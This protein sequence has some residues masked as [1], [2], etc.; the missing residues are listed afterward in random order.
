MISPTHNRLAVAYTKAEENSILVSTLVDLEGGSNNQPK[1]YT[2]L[3]DGG[4]CSNPEWATCP[5]RMACKKC[6]FHVSM[7]VARVV[8]ARKSV[9]RMP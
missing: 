8:A 5:V 4:L 2:V 3:D 9:R 1:V 7:D 6:Q